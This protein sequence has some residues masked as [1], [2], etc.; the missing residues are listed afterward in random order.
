MMDVCLCVEPAEPPSP[1]VAMHVDH[2]A[3]KTRLTSNQLLR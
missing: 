3:Y 2:N 1:L